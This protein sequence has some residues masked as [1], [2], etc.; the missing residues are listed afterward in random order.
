M[1]TPHHRG[2]G[3][4]PRPGCA[5]P[6]APAAGARPAAE[7]A[8]AA[9][10]VTT[11][12]LRGLAGASAPSP[13]T[14]RSETEPGFGRLPA[15]YTQLG[16][17]VLLPVVPPAGHELGWAVDTGRL[18]PGRF[19]LLEPA[20]PAAGPD[21]DRHGGRRRRPGTGRGARRRPA[22]PRRRLLRPGAG[23]RP[24]GTPS[25]SPSCST[26]SWSTSC[27]RSRTT[28]G[29]PPSSRPPAAGRRSR[30]RDGR[31]PDAPRR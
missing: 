24:H 13:P 1:T 11:A 22:G 16:A 3:R 10:A 28:A 20:G 19:G 5:S 8:A 26:T 21:G 30:R 9:A 17:R 7:R 4:R 12:L 15:A 31:C 29:S 27:P 14:C 18:A 25:W 2:E 6:P 23:P